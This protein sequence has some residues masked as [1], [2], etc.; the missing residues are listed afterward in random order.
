MTRSL[1][2]V[3]LALGTLLT[4]G[5]PEALACR[6]SVRDTGFVDLGAEPYRLVLELSSDAP[7][8][9]RIDF[10]QAAAAVLLDANVVFSSRPATPPS[11]TRLTLALP[12]SRDVVL[13]EAPGFPDSR[14]A[15]VALLERAVTSPMR[16]RLHDE[17]LRA[18]AVL[19]LV[20]GE[21][22]AANQRA[23]QTL[24]EAVDA[25]ANLLPSMPK[26]V[27]TPPRVLALSAK[28]IAAETVL[29]AG[30]GMTP[31]PI[32]DPRV[33]VIFGRGRRVGDAL[34]GA[35][36]TRTVVQDRLAIIGQDCECDLDR[37]ALQGP[38]IPARWDAAR[39]KTAAQTLG[40]D[41]ENPL[42]RAEISRIVL[43]GPAKP[44]GKRSV[45]GAFDALALGYAEEPVD[46]AAADTARDASDPITEPALAP[47][48]PAAGT[49]DLHPRPASRSP[50]AP[51]TTRSPPAPE[52]RTPGQ[53]LALWFSLSGMGLT[54]LTF[55]A[56]LLVRSRK[57][58]L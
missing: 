52:S 7:D 8:R 36:I 19:L 4:L 18:Y 14:A 27:E 53:V 1:P 35:L 46:A 2:I 39:Q 40:F 21:D 15:V 16:H 49:S 41:P 30:L 50:A 34:E 13:A 55:G 24:Q 28:D 57:N 48:T 3:L 29:V 42:I 45:T 37:S 17:L 23:R 44:G 33:A 22:P 47:T 38:V 51:V 56:W 5:K 20:E 12:D 11:P 43:K 58:R 9:W 6:Y 54:V 26:P 32:P 31:R 25:I 10:E